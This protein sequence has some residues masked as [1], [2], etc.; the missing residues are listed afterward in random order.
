MTSVKFTHL[1]VHSCYSLLDGA[2]TPE[3][4]V[5]QVKS[6]GQ[7]ACA[8]TDHGNLH[9][10]IKFY[11]AC[12]KEGIKPILGMEAYISPGSNKI[13]EKIEGEL[14]NYHLTLLVKEIKGLYNLYKLSSLAYI[15]GF[16]YKPRIDQE[17]LEK[18]NEGLICLSGCLTGKIAHY[19]RLGIEDPLQQDV[20]YQKAFNNAL[21]FKNLFQDRFFME[22]QRIVPIQEL[23]IPLQ[24][25][26]GQE[27]SIQ[28]I[29]SCDS[30]YLE[31]S[32]V[33]FHEQ[34]LCI[35][36]GKTIK[37]EKRMGRMEG[38]YLKSEAEMRTL[39]GDMPEV[40][41]NT[42]ILADSIQ[43]FS[44]QDPFRPDTPIFPIFSKSK[45]QDYKVFED[46]CWAGFKKRELS[47]KEYEDRLTYE[48]QV[49]N[50]MGFPSYFLVVQDYINWSKEHGIQV[51]SAR[52]SS[53][54]SLA[55]YCIGIT[56]VEP[57]KYGL[58][59][60]RFLNKGRAGTPCF[61]DII[62]KADPNMSIQQ[63]LLQIDLGFVNA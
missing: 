36:T 57:I 26:I 3:Q 51:G 60:Q 42:M 6:L 37:D 33:D 54:G 12:K 48:I 31:A 34:L 19:L 21:W 44:S 52:G 28:G 11:N 41:D 8:L 32:D 7:T 55:A 56:E 27:L 39:F 43:D 13:K 62:P 61:E 46:L 18:H 38:L 23:I 16:Y 50:E 14:P 5:K 4:I 17:L 59:F 45:E 9:G 2:M 40:V 22:Y 35:N 20:M 47:G 24:K 58:L 10:M 15:E 1:H 30:H 63:S 53:A 29:C 49:I 25:K